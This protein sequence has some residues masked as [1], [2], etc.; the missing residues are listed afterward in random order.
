MGTHSLRT[1]SAAFVA[2]GLFAM[3]AGCAATPAPRELLDARSAYI[4]AEGGVAAQLKPDQLHEA[5]VA[6]D[7]AEQSFS[8]DPGKQKTKD[9]AY[10]AERKA[11][12]A[13][14]SARDAKA[15]QEKAQAENDIRRFTQ[16]EL[17]QTRR[18]LYNAD[19]QLV[20][21]EQQLA[22]EKK[23][24]ADAEQR[25]KDA[26]DRLAA[27]S[28]SAIKQE[29]RGT[30]IPIPGSVLFASGKTALLPTAQ[31]KLG[32]VADALKDQADRRIVVEGHTDSQGTES[33]N[34]E[35]GRGRAETVRD[36]L[37]SHGVSSDR[38]RAESIGASRPMADNSSPE[39][40]ANN[41]RIEIIVQ[42][43]ESK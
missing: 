13:E 2:V 12:L 33:S 8:D 16:A 20:G 7:R 42:A 40:R 4:R 11:E 35:L 28:G 15:A 39:G 31:A 5:K 38:V 9:L 27:S 43:A 23:A 22:N 34:R 18:A 24:R 32:A 29:A 10:V 19:Q 37:V 3:S 17:S 1:N 36:F 25:A 30:V 26:M 41:R 6:L 21:T 14:V